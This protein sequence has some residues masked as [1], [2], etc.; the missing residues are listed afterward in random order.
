MLS[1]L[2]GLA[3]SRRHVHKHVHKRIHHAEANG[4]TGV[5]TPSVGVNVRSGPSTGHS[6]V[7][8]LACGATVQVNGRNGD[9]YSVTANGV[10][11]C[12]RGDLLRVP[13][14][15]NADIGLNVRSG[16]ST[17]Y[18]IVSSLANGASVSIVNIQNGWYQISN[19]WVCGDYVTLSGS[20]STGGGGTPSR[21]SGTVIRQGDSRFNSNIRNWGCAFMSCCWCGGVNSIDGCTSLYNTA[22]ANGWIRSDCYINNWATCCT[23]IGKAKSYRWASAGELPGAGNKEILQCANS[24]TSMHF[25]VGN[26]NYGIEYDPSYDGSVSYS[27]CQ[28]KRFLF[29]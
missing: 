14:V 24:R 27:D 29:Y 16:P 3:A 25:V 9:W 28:N 15:V 12:I 2:F 6:I 10:N 5:V 17:S 20:S 11:G 1:V 22:V 13:G 26:G 23:Q 21:P 8:S 19:G 7:T 18:G 4:C